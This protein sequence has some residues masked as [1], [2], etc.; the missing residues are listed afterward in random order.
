MQKLDVVGKQLPIEMLINRRCIA[1][2]GEWREGRIM[3]FDSEFAKV[4]FFDTEA[5][6]QVPVYSV[7]PNCSLSML[8]ESLGQ[9]GVACDLSAAIK[10]HSLASKSGAAREIR[11]D[12]NDGS[13]RR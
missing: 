12:R 7:I 10:R 13:A 9:A 8:E 5:E 2:K 6:E 1:G 3:E 11:E 4:H